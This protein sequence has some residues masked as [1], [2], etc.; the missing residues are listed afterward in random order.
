MYV[1]R[2]SPLSTYEDGAVL[3]SRSCSHYFSCMLQIYI[4][5]P[6]E[7][8]FLDIDPGTVLSMESVADIFDEDLS[9]GEFSLP[10]KAPWTG[11]NK[12][13]LGFAERFQNLVTPVR[14]FKCAVFDSGYPELPAGKFSIIGKTGNFSYTKGSFDFT[15]TGTKGLFGSQIKNKKVN[16]LQL[17]GKITW[18]DIDSRHFAE[19][20]MKGSYQQYNYL[21]FVPVAI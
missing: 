18:A 9:T 19:A 14:D 8:G 10:G 21:A 12:K 1:I 2:L 11:N 5:G 15:I 16:D 17:G 13:L 20:F 7:S 6:L 4:S 3:F